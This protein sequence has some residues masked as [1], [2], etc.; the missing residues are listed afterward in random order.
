MSFT[1]YFYVKNSVTPLLQAQTVVRKDVVDYLFRNVAEKYLS[2]EEI[3]PEKCSVEQAILDEAADYMKVLTGKDGG[4]SMTILPQVAEKFVV[5]VERGD[6][7]PSSILLGIEHLL[8]GSIPH[9]SP[10]TRGTDPTTGRLEIQLL[11]P[12]DIARVVKG[13]SEFLYAAKP[14]KSAQQNLV[15]RARDYS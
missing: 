13:L 10:N 6:A 2:G 15:G 8:G 12:N 7:V 11:S 14:A 3:P 9:F 4:I 1:S 5:E